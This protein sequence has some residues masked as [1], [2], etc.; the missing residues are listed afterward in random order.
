MLSQREARDLEW[1]SHSFRSESLS[2]GELCPSENIVKR[3]SVVVAKIER[4]D[5]LFL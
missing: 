4:R 1:I 5:N 2:I 3:D